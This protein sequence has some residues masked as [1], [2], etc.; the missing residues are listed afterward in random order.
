MAEALADVVVAAEV[1][2]SYAEMGEQAAQHRSAAPLMPARYR[3]LFLGCVAWGLVSF[4]RLE[5]C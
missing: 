1:G 5:V 2:A 4:R 3:H